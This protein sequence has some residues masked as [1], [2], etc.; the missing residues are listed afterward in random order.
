MTWRRAV[1]TS[2]R[3]LALR[4]LFHAYRFA[5]ALICIAALALRVLIPSG[6][7]ISGEQGQVAVTICSDGA[8]KLKS[9]DM[10]AMHHAVPESGQSPDHGKAEMPCAFSGLSLQA[11]AGMDPLVL[12]AIAFVM[13]V[14]LRPAQALAP[15]IRLYLRPP[16]RGP[17]ALA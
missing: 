9:M 13:A 11:L 2:L 6:Y 15:P 16:L 1:A 8:S 3:V 12:A 7:M 14:A 4:R 5:A 10:S 17:P